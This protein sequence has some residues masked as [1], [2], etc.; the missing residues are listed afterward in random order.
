MNA[1]TRIVAVLLLLG[2]IALGGYKW[3]E[4]RSQDDRQLQ[5]TDARTTKG[6]IRVARDGWVGY[7]HLCSPDMENRLRRQGYLLECLDDK[8]NY[9][10]RFR[11]LD[12]GDYQF[13]V[14]TIDSYVQNGAS[15]NY[16]G[17]IIAVIDE[18]KGGDALVARAARVDSIEALRS[19]TD[20]KIAFTPDS[21]SEHLLRALRSHFDLVQLTHKGRWRVPVQGSEEALEKLKK[22][23]VDVA[24]LWEP[25]V[26]RAL[27]LP[28]MVRL[29]GTENTRKLIVDVL[30]A[31]P[32]TLRNQPELVSA[33]LTAWFQTQQ[34]YRR[35]PQEM[36]SALKDQYKVSNAQAE[37]LMKGVDWKTLTDN[38]YDWYGGP[39][40]QGGQ[41]SLVDAITSAV[42]ILQDDQ[43]FSR[44]P[45]PDG[46]PYRLV[47]SAL[48]NELYQT[49]AF[50]DLQDGGQSAKQGVTFKPLSDE[51]WAQ[52][53]PV[54]M[55]KVR[56]IQFASGA[57]ELTLDGKRE[58]DSLM[59]HLQHY[60][61]FRVEIRGHTGTRGDE[62]A[63]RLLSQDRAE[64]VHRYIEVTYGIEPNR[65]RAI[66]H[67]GTRP[68]PQQPG[69]SDRAYGYRLPRVEVVL[70]S[71]EI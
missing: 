40:R 67:G 57:A 46:N 44:N 42:N 59:E 21:P 58:I 23:E 30:I 61:N 31:N 49:L 28:G 45:L 51:E 20:L 37:Q 4:L 71:G 38:L 54:G 27:E 24:V 26:T 47:N 1:H 41:E 35:N 65:F 66:G 25:D 48:I 8:A 17:P 7:F 68:L 29:L 36:I 6:T 9:Q 2:L 34:H 14:G 32:K 22:G 39:N 33:F 70:V 18:S 19:A 16:P 43:V 52:L 50:G 69:E 5:T 56:P 63:N 53:R 12:K 13:A 62:D 3:W 11:K 64:A 15:L 10:E 55:L 60:P